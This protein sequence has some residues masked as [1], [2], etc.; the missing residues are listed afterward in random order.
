MPLSDQAIKKFKPADKPYK[1]ADVKGL[2]L[3]F[4]VAGKYGRMNY[5][6]DGNHGQTRAPFSS[7]SS[8]TPLCPY[9]MPSRSSR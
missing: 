7:A 5:R 2:Y 1:K 9:S 3:R 4:N 8:I 6:F